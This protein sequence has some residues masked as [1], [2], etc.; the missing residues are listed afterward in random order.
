M[1]VAR[2]RDPVLR[3]AVRAAAHPEEDVVTDSALVSLA[4]KWGSPRLV[5]LADEAVEEHRTGAFRVVALDEG[6]LARWETDRRGEDV[7]APRHEYLTGCLSGL[8]ERSVHDMTWV[9]VTLADLGRAAGAPLP[10]TLR[11]FVRR[12]L[13]FPVHYTTLH[14]LAERCDVTRGALKAR[15][16]RRG[17]ASPY[18]YLRWLRSFAVSEMLADTEVP[19]AKAALALGFS[20]AGNLCRTTTAVTNL[21]TSE[22]RTAR[23]RN[24]LLI[25]FAWEHLTPAALSAWGELDGLF[26]RQAA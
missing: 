7:P 12:V 16:R 1:I 9:D 22:L 6:T 20:S 11:T 24:G 5:V 21:T 25:R 19:V 10:A 18:T 13:E 2:V 14:E 15:F 17:L 23:G 3:A 4:L 26:E 8:L